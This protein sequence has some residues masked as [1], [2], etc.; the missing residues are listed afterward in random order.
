[1]DDC[2]L[3]PENAKDWAK[4]PV[5]FPCAYWHPPKA[6]DVQRL[7]ADFVG[8]CKASVGLDEQDARY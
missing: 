4:N 6:L 5:S 7:V 2:Q 3:A 8:R 1:M